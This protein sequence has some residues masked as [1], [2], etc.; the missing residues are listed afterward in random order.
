MKHFLLL[1]ACLFWSAISVTA[2]SNSNN[3]TELL[4]QKN[5]P[6]VLNLLNHPLQL[7]LATGD[8][9]LGAFQRLILDRKAILEGLDGATGG[10]VA[11]E[12]AA[13]EEQSAKWLDAGKK[14]GKT[15]AVEGIECYNCGGNHLNIDCPDDQEI[16]SSARALQSLLLSN[17][18]DGAT[19]VL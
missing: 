5:R 11:E 3:P 8:L 10:L 17:G 14:A 9:K 19:A 1:Q 12:L 2:L 7:Q 6:E 18:W 4:F 15:I 16:S 13:H